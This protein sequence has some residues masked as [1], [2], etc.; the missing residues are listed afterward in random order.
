MRAHWPQ[1]AHLS[2]ESAAQHS[3]ELIKQQEM[4]YDTYAPPDLW[5][6]DRLT[7]ISKTIYSLFFEGGHNDFKVYKAIADSLQIHKIMYCICVTKQL[8]CIVK[9]VNFLGVLH[10]CETFRQHS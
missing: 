6:S 10:M 9:F 5:P 2:A 7:D 1:V 3:S 8:I 4:S